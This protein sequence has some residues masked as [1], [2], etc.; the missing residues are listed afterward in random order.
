MANTIDLRGN[1]QIAT[2]T[3]AEAYAA[4]LGCEMMYF[5]Y[6]P[7]PQDVDPRVAVKF[8][9]SNPFFTQDMDRF[10]GKDGNQFLYNTAMYKC[11]QTWSLRAYHGATVV[12]KM[13]VNLSKG[14]P[15]AVMAA[16]I[17]SSRLMG[18]GEEAQMS[19]FI[20]RQLCICNRDRKHVEECLLKAQEHQMQYI[21]NLKAKALLMK[22]C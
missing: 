19:I 16:Y 9:K 20:A 22:D 14:A 21:E 7:E 11:R 17:D 8:G 12:E 2:R 4:A 13:L 6:S 18:V 3:E 5:G 15:L 1:E 10:L